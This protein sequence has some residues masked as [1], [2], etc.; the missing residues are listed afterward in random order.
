MAKQ[1]FT[2]WRDGGGSSTVK[3]D[4]HWQASTEADRLAH[5]N[6][7]AKFHVMQAVETHTVVGKKIE[8]Y[9]EPPIVK[10]AKSYRVQRAWDKK[11]HEPARYY[12][13][14]EAS[15][16]QS[17]P[18]VA[19]YELCQLIDYWLEVNETIYCDVKDGVITDAYIDLPF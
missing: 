19:N 18:R 15:G 9:D 17:L 7:G 6:H 3:H 5:A 2:V 14:H 16:T 11:P 13:L 10:G 1:F 4:E 8:R 12:V